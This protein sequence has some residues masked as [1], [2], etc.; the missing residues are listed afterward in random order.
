MIGGIGMLIAFA[1]MLEDKLLIRKWKKQR[2]FAEWCIA[3]AVR[4]QEEHLNAIRGTGLVRND[5]DD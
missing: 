5:K 3:E 1:T 2:E 4:K